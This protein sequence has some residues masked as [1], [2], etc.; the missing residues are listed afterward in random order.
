MDAPRYSFHYA[1]AWMLVP[2]L[3]TLAVM[4]AQAAQAI[5][6]TSA[7]SRELRMA[8]GHSRVVAGEHLHLTETLETRLAKDIG[9]QWG[10]P[11]AAHRADN[12]D[13]LAMLRTGSVDAVLTA[14]P[15]E[16]PLPPAWER[17]STGYAVAPM[18]IMRSDTD[19]RSWKQLKGRTV[20]LTA[21]G[22]YAG[23]PARQYGAREI[24]F[25]LISDALLGV[26]TGK[27]DAV[28]HDDIVLERLLTLPEWKKFSAR[29]PA[30]SFVPLVLV[31]PRKEGAANRFAAV[32]GQWRA[33][34][35]SDPRVNGLVNQIAF[36]V[37]L[38]QDVPDCH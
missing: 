34:R 33:A 21:Q 16:V 17:I 15:D 29:L 19:V 6:Q 25:D 36:D 26:R 20:C 28:V 18:A 8:V 37:Y 32:A 35:G 4:S 24:H 22:R 11:V 1:A 10:M 5:E 30:G 3:S 38:K 14:L 13:P 23:M 31:F 27:C 2:L 7:A 9:Q 12:G